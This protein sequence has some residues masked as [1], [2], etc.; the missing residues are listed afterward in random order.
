MNN[1]GILGVES[2]DLIASKG[3]PSGHDLGFISAL[4]E[5]VIEVNRQPSK[6]LEFNRQ[7]SKLEKFNR[8]SYDPIETLL[9]GDSTRRHQGYFHTT[10]DFIAFAP[11]RKPQG[12][13]WHWHKNSDFGS[14]SVTERNCVAPISKWSRINRG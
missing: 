11:A 1:T 12:S 6:S 9:K 7:P 5:G 13:C 14:I 10:L 8:Q 4:K 3:D 2:L